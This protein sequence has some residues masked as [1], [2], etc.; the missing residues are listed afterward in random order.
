[1]IYPGCL[2]LALVLLLLLLVP[3]FF[4]QFMLAALT[5]LGLSPGAA[6]AILLGVILGSGVNIPIKRFHRDEEILVD[7]FVMFGFSRLFSLPLRRRRYMTLAVNVG[8]CVI[9]SLLAIYECLLVAQRGAGDLTILAAVTLADVAVCYSLARPVPRLGITIPALLPPLVAASLSLV[10]IPDFAP[11][12]AFVAG[13]LG[14]LIG[15]DLMHLKEIVRIAPVTASIGGA[16]T[17]DGIILSGLAAALL[18]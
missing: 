16:G 2:A 5:K 18:A 13:V 7:P 8:G 14:P 6:L 9:P 17:F 1:M 11:P 3:F 10:L 4:A 12:V 15:A